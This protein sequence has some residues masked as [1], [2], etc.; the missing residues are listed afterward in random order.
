MLPCKYTKFNSERESVNSIRI[1][2]KLLLVIVLQ[3]F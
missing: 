3:K 1:T 2:K